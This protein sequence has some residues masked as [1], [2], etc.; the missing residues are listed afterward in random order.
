[1]KTIYGPLF[2]QVD[3][4]PASACSSAYNRIGSEQCQKLTEQAG[5][6]LADAR[7]PVPLY[8]IAAAAALLG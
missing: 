2:T 7:F 5:E 3:S 1:M 8:L 6:T 4:V